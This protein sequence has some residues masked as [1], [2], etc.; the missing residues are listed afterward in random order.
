ML[1]SV[2]RSA[3][4]LASLALLTCVCGANNRM[5]AQNGSSQL[6]ESAKPPN[7]TDASATVQ[8][9]V[10]PIA[11]EIPP[12]YSGFYQTTFNV[13][14]LGKPR[15]SLGHRLNLSYVPKFGGSFDARF[16]YFVDGSYNAD[17][18]GVLRNNINEPKFE[19]QLMYNRPLNERFG[20]TGGALHHHNFRFPD[21]YVLA[22]GGLTAEAPIGKNVTFSGA[23]LLEKKSSV[24]VF[25]NLSGT[26]EYR[27]APKWNTQ[28]SYARLENVGQFDL[29]PTQVEEYEIG[30]NRELN[31]QQSVGISF[32]RHIQF[33]APNDQFSFL[34]FKYGVGF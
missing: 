24:R 4:C 27:F 21:N 18:V 3:F 10:A 30:V 14:L 34:K 26:L 6:P 19:A 32:F 25:Y 33:N 17:P 16:E 5:W 12:T 7:A 1:S 28:F 15:P 23:A 9:D 31:R 22:V 20:I 8:P 11:S 13:S 29:K 2:R